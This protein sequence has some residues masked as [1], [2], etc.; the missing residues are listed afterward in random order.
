MLLAET[1]PR[2]VERQLRTK[3]LQERRRR[4][5]KNEEKES[6]NTF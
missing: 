4:G 1:L 3:I 2:M 6:W 5:W